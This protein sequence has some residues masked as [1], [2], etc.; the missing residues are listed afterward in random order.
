MCL[1]LGADAL[2]DVGQ[3]AQQRRLVIAPRRAARF[4][5]RAVTTSSGETVDQ[6]DEEVPRAH[7]GIDRP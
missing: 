1:G 6:I 2:A 4:A 7:R 5:H 3:R